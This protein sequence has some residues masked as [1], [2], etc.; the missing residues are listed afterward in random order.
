MVAGGKKDNLKY[1][2]IEMEKKEL[3]DCLCKSLMILRSFREQIR[4]NQESI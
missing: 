4:P 2:M 1:E 3:K